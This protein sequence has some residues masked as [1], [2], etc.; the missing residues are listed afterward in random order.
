M[1]FL[2][3]SAFV[4]LESIFPA[5]ELGS[6]TRLGHVSLLGT[7]AVGVCGSVFTSSRFLSYVSLWY[8]LGLWG[9]ARLWSLDPLLSF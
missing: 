3:F 9:P 4:L 5:N 6:P 7:W 8:Y 1:C 2:V